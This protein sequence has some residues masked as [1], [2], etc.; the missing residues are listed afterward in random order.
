[1]AHRCLFLLAQHVK[2]THTYCMFVTFN[3]C[4]C[5]TH[6]TNVKKHLQQDF[7]AHVNNL[8]TCQQDGPLCISFHLCMRRWDGVVST[9]SHVFII[10]AASITF[11]K[12]YKCVNQ[13]QCKCYWHKVRQVVRSHLSPDKILTPQYF[14]Q[15]LINAFMPSSSPPLIVLHGPLPAAGHFH[16]SARAPEQDSCWLFITKRTQR[17]HGWQLLTAKWCRW[18][19]CYSLVV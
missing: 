16:T 1:M 10:Q 8:F 15:Q 7:P 2:E 4:A 17:V 14:Y 11:H 3:K 5:L 19:N 18:A 12:M 9:C 13:C 6:I